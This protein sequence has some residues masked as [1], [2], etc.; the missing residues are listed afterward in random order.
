LGLSDDE[1]SY[2]VYQKEMENNA[3]DS[4][5]DEIKILF[6]DGSLKDIT[7]ASDNLNIRALSNVVKKH[8]LFSPSF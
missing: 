5:K 4:A 1:I 7:D 2:F 8:Y 3:Y 6:K